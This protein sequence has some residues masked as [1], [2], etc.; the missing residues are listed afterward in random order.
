MEQDCASVGIT[1][2]NNKHDMEDDGRSGSKIGKEN[3]QS[4]EQDTPIPI[5]TKTVKG[6]VCNRS[7]AATITKN[8]IKCDRNL[9]V[10]PTGLDDHGNRV[11][12]FDD[13]MVA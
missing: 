7:F 13:V 12:V 3:V 10:I 11:V 9:K 5:T 8:I 4:N 1:E 6:S 2:D